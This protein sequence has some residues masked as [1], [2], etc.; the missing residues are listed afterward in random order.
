MLLIEVLL[1]ECLLVEQPLGL[2]L[3]EV[4]SHLPLL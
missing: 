4:Y 2:V 1:F 3:H